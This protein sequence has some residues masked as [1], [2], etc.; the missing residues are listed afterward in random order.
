MI[1]LGPKLRRTPVTVVS[2]PVKMA[3]TPMIVPVPMITPRTVSRARSLWDRIACSASVMPFVK[4]SQFIVGYF[5]A[6]NASIRSSLA[7]WRAG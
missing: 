5:S 3:L 4:A 1:E 6:R 7:A 2:K